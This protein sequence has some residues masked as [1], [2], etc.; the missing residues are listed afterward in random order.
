MFNKYLV[1]LFFYLVWVGK[2]NSVRHKL[3]FK[4]AFEFHNGKI[5]AIFR[6]V[7]ETVKPNPKSVHDKS[8]IG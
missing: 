1:C 8:K 2:F 7:R 6:N 3:K 5:K 4:L